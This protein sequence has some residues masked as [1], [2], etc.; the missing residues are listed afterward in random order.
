MGHRDRQRI[1]TRDKLSISMPLTHKV[2]LLWMTAN[3]I[4]LFILF[5][6]GGA[7]TERGSRL[8]VQ[9]YHSAPSKLRWESEAA[10]VYS[11]QHTHTH[12]HTHCEGF[13][14]CNDSPSLYPNPNQAKWPAIP[15]VC[16]SSPQVLG[17]Q[18]ALLSWQAEDI[19]AKWSGSPGE[20][21]F[22]CRQLESDLEDWIYL[23][24]PFTNPTS[25]LTL[26]L[27]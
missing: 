19:F 18:A 17:F 21:I 10:Q 6:H 4:A 7:G 14:R 15:Q 20:T 22:I 26:R 3:R 13:H 11:L 1:H 9:L 24:W 25:L 8:G 23:L 27:P 12:T 16:K 5:P 2:L